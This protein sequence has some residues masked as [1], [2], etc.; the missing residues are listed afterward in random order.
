MSRCF[1]LRRL[2]GEDRQGLGKPALVSMDFDG[3]V[4]LAF[5]RE[6]LRLVA[7][8]LHEPLAALRLQ[9]GVAEPLRRRPELDLRPG[10][11]VFKDL[12]CP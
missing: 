3:A 8:Q 1:S 5:D 7:P 11:L 2:G 4:H 6:E 9:L 10:S 12:A